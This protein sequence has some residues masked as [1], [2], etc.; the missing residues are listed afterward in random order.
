LHDEHDAKRV[1]DVDVADTVA[2]K[3]AQTEEPFNL[4]RYLEQRQYIICWWLEDGGLVLLCLLLFGGCVLDLAWR[5]YLYYHAPVLISLACVALVS[6]S[7]Q[8]LLHVWWDFFIRVRRHRR[9]RDGLRRVFSVPLP[10]STR[11]VSTSTST[12]ICVRHPNVSLTDD[13]SLLIANASSLVSCQSPMRRSALESPRALKKRLKKKKHASRSGMAT[14]K[15]HV[16]EAIKESDAECAE[17][18]FSDEHMDEFLKE[19]EQLIKED[20]QPLHQD[21]DDDDDEKRAPSTSAAMAVTIEHD[22]DSVDPA[23]DTNICHPNGNTLVWGSFSGCTAKTLKLRG[24]T[25]LTDKVKVSSAEALLSLA[26][27]DIFTV[28]NRISHLAQHPVSWFHQN[29]KKLPRSL[30][31][32]IVHLRLDSMQ[33][34]IVQ[35]FYIDRA[36]FAHLLQQDEKCAAAAHEN[37]DGY[38]AIGGQQFDESG[39]FWNFINGPCKYRND[40]LKL[41]ARKEEGP[42]YMQ[43]PTR[44]AILGRQV[45]IEY[46]RGYNAKHLNAVKTH[47]T[48]SCAYEP[49][50]FETLYHD[51]NKTDGGDTAVD[52]PCQCGKCFW[53]DTNGE[54]PDYLELDITPE[55][56]SVARNTVRIACPLAKSLQVE[57]HWTMEGQINNVELP[58]RMLCSARL[59]HIDLTK[60]VELD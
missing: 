25:Y 48:N 18:P 29:R 13:Q 9:H 11:W 46:Y 7:P 33:T 49:Y 59:I 21:D 30:F 20:E 52:V 40:R 39:M 43:I 51:P 12:S 53:V 34:S 28:H 22:E 5:E 1:V 26:N 3:N 50:N 4:M 24:A 14:A 60:I 17:R 32:F 23:W 36:Q 37:G 31:F 10:S 38:F 54:Y 15:T 16:T 6:I 19:T 55:V 8:S 56:N 27:M 47:S 44:P 41:L 42:W 45:P 57:M 2:K 58:E 35:Y